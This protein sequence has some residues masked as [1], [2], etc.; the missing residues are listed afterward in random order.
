M[1]IAKAIIE[2]DKVN[3]IWRNNWPKKDI[4]FHIHL[5]VMNYPSQLIEEAV[6]E[7]SKFPGIG[8]KSAMRMVLYL[9]KQQQT[10]V[11]RMGEAIIK[12]RANIKYC[13][14]CG[15]VSDAEMCNICS[16][17]KRNQQLICVVEDLRDVIAIENT[18]QFNGTYHIL[19]ALISPING[20]GPDKL[21]IEKLIQRISDERT[22][23]VILA[24]SATVE[25]DTTAFYVSKK[26]NTLSVKV[27]SISRGIAIGGELEY[28]DEVTLGRSI[29]L[30]MP[31]QG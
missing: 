7:L 27:S 1:D 14:R 8:K 2:T 30:R 4:K 19:G 13:N 24:L 15:N 5:P 10:D 16:N 23:E 29:A 6:N 31:F 26:L 28:A 21:N 20:V 11:T 18:G 25:G 9:L 22:Q 12:L 17:P 3:H